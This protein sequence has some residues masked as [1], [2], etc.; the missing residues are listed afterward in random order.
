MSDYTTVS[1]N[2]LPAVNELIKF[3]V[4]DTN[5]YLEESD[6]I[7]RLNIET[8]RVVKI[9]P[10]HGAYLIKAVMELSLAGK[11][12]VLQCFKR[13][14]LLPIFYADS[15]GVEIDND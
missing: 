3:A 6:A 14:G 5:N 7:F 2:G 12:V 15:I 4:R 10:A 11:E 1:A 9:V 8:Y 13:Y